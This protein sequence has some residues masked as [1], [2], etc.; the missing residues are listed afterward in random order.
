MKDWGEVSTLFE[1]IHKSAFERTLENVSEAQTRFDVI[2]RIIKEILQWK[3]GQISVEPHIS[4]LK[5]GYVD[6]ILVAS[7]Y[8]IIIEAKKVG[9]AFPSPTR[10]KKLKLTGAIL[11][12]GEIKDALEQAETY[13]KERNADIVMVTN[14]TCWC[15]YPLGE[16]DKNKIYANLLFPFEDLSDA[17]KLFNLFEVH[18]VE[19]DSLKSISIDNDL[20]LNNKLNNIVDNCDLRVGRNNIADFI[21]PAIDYAIMAEA[22]LEDEIAL[23]NC[24]VTSDSRVKFDNTLQMHL[25]QYKP[26]II[27]P[28]KKIKRDKNKDEFSNSIE[29]AKPSISSPVTLL[30]GSVGSGKSTYLKHFE[31]VQSKE[32]LKQQKAH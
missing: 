28:A 13:A 9:S 12:S 30:I 15:F 31:L 10:R 14:G 24:Y 16:S 22:L 5:N 4:G 20:I 17:E 19:N 23:K 18:N 7:D 8:S 25:A 1:A 27:Y 11:G 3:N 21:M 26:E 2:D 6:Y 29:I 32:L